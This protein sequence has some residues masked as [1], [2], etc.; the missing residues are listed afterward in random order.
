M[1]GGMN[2]N[3]VASYNYANTYLDY[4]NFAPVPVIGN[5][6][7]ERYSHL[8]LSYSHLSTIIVIHNSPNR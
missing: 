6:P 5:V 4:M 7:R 3:L 8:L 1:S 2:G